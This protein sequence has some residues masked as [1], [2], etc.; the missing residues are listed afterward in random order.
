MELTT[1][2]ALVAI[3]PIDGGRVSS[4]R[5]D[6]LELLITEGA[7]PTRWGSFPM[8]PWAGRLGFARLYFG[9]TNVEFPVTSAPHANH[10][11]AMHNPWEVTD[12]SKTS[13][14]L[15]TDLQQPWPFGGWVEQVFELAV[16]HFRVEMTIH[17]DD[18]A[19][20]AQL[21]W[22]PWYRRELER[23]EP[24]EITFGADS[25][26]VVDSA[27]LPTGELVSAPPGPWDDTFTN[28]SQQPILR[29]GDALT[30]K[31][32]SDM[33]HWVVFTRP[34]HAVAIEPQSGAPNDLN[35]APHVLQP[36]DSLSGWMQLSWGSSAQ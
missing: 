19:M 1:E 31:L 26:Y 30:V 29:W 33:N 2:R 8:A 11:T 18:Q 12:F 17:A 34:D 35:R 13:L 22:H 4:L 10:G 14:R 16:D 5:V 32:T 7:K 9:N 25:M 20:P 15:R 27:Q 36:G 6:G 21:G 3:D 24:L 28:V 23:G